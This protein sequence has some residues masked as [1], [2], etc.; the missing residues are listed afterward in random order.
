MA[1]YGL[2][3]NQRD[4]QK[5]YGS[6]TEPFPGTEK[7][8]RGRLRAE[9]ANLIGRCLRTV[10]PELTHSASKLLAQHFLKS[11]VASP[12][13]GVQH[14][15]LSIGDDF[16]LEPKTFKGPETLVEA[17]QNDEPVA[18]FLSEVKRVV[19]LEKQERREKEERVEEIVEEVEEDIDRNSVS[20]LSNDVAEMAV[21]MPVAQQN[22]EQQSSS[23]DVAEQHDMASAIHKAASAAAAEA[24]VQ[25]AAKQVAEAVSQQNN[26]QQASAEEEE[27]GGRRC[28]AAKRHEK[29]AH[30]SVAQ[31]GK[32]AFGEVPKKHS[33]ARRIQAA[34]AKAAESVAKH[35]GGQRRSAAHKAHAHQADHQVSSSLYQAFAPKHRK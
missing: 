17:V 23:S 1:S 2:T 34:V 5:R 21:S 25:E 3:V 31:G 11:S 24:A 28:R 29:K 4:V 22:N 13:L 12:D 35:Q 19:H 32:N 33:K 15:L 10:Y 30:R 14:A 18:A 26:E 7:P 20:A 16:G 27:A 9:D 8:Y 6:L